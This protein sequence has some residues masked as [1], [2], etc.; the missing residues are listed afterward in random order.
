MLCLDTNSNTYVSY[1]G[2][3]NWVQ[4][5]NV[6]DNLGHIVCIPDIAPFGRFLTFNNNPG[7]TIKYNYS[8]DEGSTWTQVLTSPLDFQGA[9]AV[10]VY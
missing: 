6:N 8:D 9:R 7:L 5:S 10:I 2:G 4:V 3:N 1:D